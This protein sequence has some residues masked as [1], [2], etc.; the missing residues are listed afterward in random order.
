MIIDLALLAFCLILLWEVTRIKRVIGR[1]A[2]GA[3]K[4]FA[5]LKDA[6]TKIITVVN[7]NTKNTQAISDHLEIEDA[8]KND[9]RDLH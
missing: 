2:D 3:N 5:A 8:F 6:Q 7:I 4:N 1:N 9:N